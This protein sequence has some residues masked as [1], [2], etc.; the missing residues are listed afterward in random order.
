[1]KLQPFNKTIVGAIHSSLGDFYF[2]LSLGTIDVVASSILCGK[3]KLIQYLTERTLMPDDK[4]SEV[5]NAITKISDDVMVKFKGAGRTNIEVAFRSM[6]D[7]L[8]K[9]K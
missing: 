2:T 9:R 3:L 5:I 1:M 7:G 6:I 8:N 4:T